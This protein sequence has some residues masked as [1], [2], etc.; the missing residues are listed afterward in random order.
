MYVIY[1]HCNIV[2]YKL[3]R[4]IQILELFSFLVPSVLFSFQNIAEILH[5]KSEYHLNGY[6]NDIRIE[7]HMD[8]AYS[9]S[10]F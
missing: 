9:W 5:M 4:A 10:N 3:L 7:I 8:S 6:G 2:N 1:K